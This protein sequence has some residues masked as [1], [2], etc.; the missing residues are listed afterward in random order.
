MD[1]C[2]ARDAK[3]VAK[4]QR[5]RP[6][7]RMR[8]LSAMSTTVKQCKQCSHCVSQFRQDGL[9]LMQTLREIDPE[10]EKVVDGEK[11][12]ATPEMCVEVLRKITD[13]N[14]RLMGLNPQWCRPDWM[15]VQGRGVRCSFSSFR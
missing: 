3:F 6:A 2:L 7:A 1:G 13:D 14:V 10:T 12:V 5:M 15:I 4:L 9:K 8:E 11:R